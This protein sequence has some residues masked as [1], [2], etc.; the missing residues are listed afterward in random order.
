MR[1]ERKGET[2]G[3]RGREGERERERERE[4]RLEREKLS[5]GLRERVF[6]LVRR[7]EIKGNTGNR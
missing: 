1:G 3:G 5:I 4:R 6:H 2:E 7:E